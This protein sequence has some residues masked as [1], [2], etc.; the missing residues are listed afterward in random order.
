[1]KPCGPVTPTTPLAPISPMFKRSPLPTSA[2]KGPATI[3]EIDSD[4]EGE[5]EE[6]GV[7]VI[8]DSEDDDD[9]DDSVM[10]LDPAAWA[11]SGGGGGGG[12]GGAGGGKKRKARATAKRGAAD[13]KGTGKGKG[14]APFKGGGGGKKKKED[15]NRPW[16]DDAEAYEFEVGGLLRAA[17]SEGYAI[18]DPQPPGLRVS[19]FE[20]QRSTLQVLSC[21]VLLHTRRRVKKQGEDGWW[22]WCVHPCIHMYAWMVALDAAQAHSHTHM[23]NTPRAVDVGQGA[24]PAGAERPLLGGVELDG[25]QTGRGG[26]LLLLP[27]GRRTA[28]RQ[29]ARHHG[30]AAVRGDGLGGLGGS[31][32]RFGLGSVVCKTKTNPLIPFSPTDTTQQGKTVELLA[33]VLANPRKAP[34]ALLTSASSTSSLGAKARGAG[35]ATATASASST[36]ASTSVVPSGATLII[37]PGT[38]LGQYITEIDKC[39]H[40]G[41]TPTAVYVGGLRVHFY[42]RQL[43]LVGEDGLV[44]KR[45]VRGQVVE[46][47]R[48][49]APVCVFDEE[50]EDGEGGVGAASA[51]SA[52]S[53]A[54]AGAGATAADEEEAERERRV[55]LRAQ[56]Y[57]GVVTRVQAG[58][59]TVGGCGCALFWYVGK[60]FVGR[61]WERRTDAWLIDEL[62]RGLEC[63]YVRYASC[64]HAP[65]PSHNLIPPLVFRRWCNTPTPPR[66]WRG[67]ASC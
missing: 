6:T 3:I 19:L 30:R 35:A 60:R 63:M 23:Q 58:G 66:G 21:R 28:H 57:E 34:P 31:P 9:D 32:S 47:M 36:A 53:A 25:R 13:G 62:G 14:K 26:L 54:G 10:I 37:T 55:R 61:K 48:V 39:T 16:G 8:G 33:L 4:E 64:I 2:V 29:A 40:M 59:D 43:R 24:G 5:E 49:L 27:G 18:R 52:A 11:R 7:V 17:E 12:G 22:P 51:A 45:C 20:F 15:G 56:Y 46:G 1:M 65:N 50:G 67:R 44:G 38:L 41:A 42:T